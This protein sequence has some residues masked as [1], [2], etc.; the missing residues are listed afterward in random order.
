MQIRPSTLTKNKRIIALA[1]IV[2]II[3]GVFCTRLPI[4]S[5]KEADRSKL[6]EELRTFADILTI[7]QRDY[8]DDVKSKKLV[9]GAITGMLTNLDPHSGYLNPTFYKEL[10]AETKGEFGGLGIEIT[11]RG[12]LLTVVSPMEGGPAYRVGVKAK[13]IIVKINGVYTK[14]LT[15]MGAVKQL[16]GK[17]G[18]SVTISVLRE[19]QDD[20]L[21][22]TIIRD[23]IALKSIKYRYLSDGFGYLRI[24]QFLETTASDLKKALAAMDKKVKSGQLKGLVLDLRNN[25]GG[26][27]AQ[28]VRVGDMFLKEGVIV[29]T[30]GRVEDQKQKYFAHVQGTEPEYPVVVLVNGGS[31]SAAE[32]VSGALQDAGRSLIVGT[33]TFGK[34]S[35]Q[36]ITPL[37]NGGALTL[38]TALYYT[39][40]GRSIQ[41]TGVKPDIEVIE[42]EQGTAKTSSEKKGKKKGRSSLL[43]REGD[44]PGAIHNPNGA[45]GEGA[46]K[47]INKTPPT[48]PEVAY[49][50]PET[51]KISE[52]LKRDNQFAK[53]VEL[54]KTFDVFKEKGSGV[55][56]AA[57]E[58]SKVL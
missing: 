56:T 9:E 15:L 5:A 36:T 51:I 43:I 41:V 58:E 4:L 18:T 12:G 2:G 1:L 7:V 29:Y 48:T 35:V 33:K 26:L 39:K 6:F 24:T 54:L 42:E 14:N 3:L 32:I 55:A 37:R 25:P 13:D 57:K 8:V 23:I 44:L 38:T 45:G 53:A 16:R 17:K 21:D 46:L 10:Q 30:D 34:G 50:D 49:I 27:L 19:G 22:F 47:K 52:W 11:N 40:S 31:A 28:A 20:L